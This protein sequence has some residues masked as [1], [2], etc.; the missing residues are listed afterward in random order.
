MEGVND[1][2]T[3]YNGFVMQHIAETCRKYSA[4]MF[5]DDVLSLT[6]ITPAGS[7]KAD[8]KKKKL[9]W[10]ETALNPEMPGPVLGFL[11]PTLNG[12]SVH[13]YAVWKRMSLRYSLTAHKPSRG[14]G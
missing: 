13:V 6:G 4:L 8:C 7:A 9:I 12:T 14:A 3:L 2:D 11:C 10:S 5:R 1:A